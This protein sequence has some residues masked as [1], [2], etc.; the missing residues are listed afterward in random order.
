MLGRAGQHFLPYWLS[1]ARP[2]IEV[3]RLQGAVFA[4]LLQ[5]ED[6]TAVGPEL[7]AEQLLCIDFPGGLRRIGRSSR[8]QRME[9]AGDGEQQ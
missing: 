4:D 9:R 2:G 3:S 1:Q 8:R 6:I 7:L 5:F